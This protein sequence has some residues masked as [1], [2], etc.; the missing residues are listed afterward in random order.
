MTLR[1]N[2]RGAQV[3]QLQSELKA[4]GISPGKIDGVVWARHARGGQALPGE[5]PP[6]RGRRRR[7]AHLEQAD[8]RWSPSRWRDG[9]ASCDAFGSARYVGD[10]LRERPAAP[11]PDRGSRQRQV[12]AQRRRG[13]VQPHEGGCSSRRHQPLGELRLPHDGAAARARC[14]LPRWPRQPARPGYSNHQGGTAAD[15][16]T[17]GGYGGRTYAWLRRNARN[18][19]FVNDV[20]GEPWHW[21]YKR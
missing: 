8:D 3:R 20:R 9:R 15:I 10:G 13:S 11:H 7:P 18:Y 21:T 4:A 1:I 17:P 6:L 14:R 2:S 12:T 16:S 5:V 19:G